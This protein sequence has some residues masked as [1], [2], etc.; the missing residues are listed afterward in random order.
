[1]QCVYWCY[2]GLS[3]VKGVYHAL[4][5]VIEVGKN[6]TNKVCY[7]LMV[8]QPEKLHFQLPK[9]RDQLK[10]PVSHSVSFI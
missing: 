2:N 10:K 5:Q 1:M 7:Q 9:F 6:E 8:R 3:L 4:H